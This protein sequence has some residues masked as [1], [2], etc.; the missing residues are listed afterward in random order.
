[1]C[2]YGFT[3]EAFFPMI[4]LGALLFATGLSYFFNKKC[5][6]CLCE[7]VLIFILTGSFFILFLVFQ[8]SCNRMPIG[9]IIVFIIIY[10]LFF[11]LFFLLERRMLKPALLK[12]LHISKTEKY[13]SLLSG[14]VSFAIFFFLEFVI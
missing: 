9:A 11:W 2:G 6:W 8:D 14:I 12:K 3:K 4:F 5:H 13:L 1:M 7:N 10:L